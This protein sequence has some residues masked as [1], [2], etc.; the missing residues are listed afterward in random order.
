MYYVFGIAYPKGLQNTL[1]F[2]ERYVFGKVDRVYNTVYACLY[3]NMVVQHVRVH[4]KA[5]HRNQSQIKH[6]LA[7]TDERKKYK[8]LP[9]VD[10]DTMHQKKAYLRT[11]PMH[12]RR[13]PYC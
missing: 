12:K 10:A 11:K 3:C 2:L 1:R 8:T 6:I 4:L 7:E 9:G 13:K 5:K